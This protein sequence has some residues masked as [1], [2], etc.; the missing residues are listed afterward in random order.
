LQSRVSGSTL[1][2]VVRRRVAPSP[3]KRK[4][5]SDKPRSGDIITIEYDCIKA[6]KR[7]RRYAAQIC[8][9]SF[10]PWSRFAPT[11]ATEISPLRGYKKTKR[12]KIFSP[13][14]LCSS[15]CSLRILC[16]LCGYCYLKSFYSF[17]FLLNYCCSWCLWCY[18]LFLLN[19][20]YQSAGGGSVHISSYG[21]WKRVNHF[22][23]GNITIH[24]YFICFGRA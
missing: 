24:S 1:L 6:N 14:H 4:N 5:V 7:Y 3:R 2:A 9:S 13:L 18:F 11:T 21:G 15:L 16:E 8:G 12:A 22:R 17:T 10:F 19:I 23:F 20:I